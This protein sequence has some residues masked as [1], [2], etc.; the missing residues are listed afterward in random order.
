MA[1][2]FSASPPGARIGLPANWVPSPLFSQ[3]PTALPCP[4]EER[5]RRVVWSYNGTVPF[6]MSCQLSGG[7]RDMVVVVAWW[8]W[9]GGG[10]GGAVGMVWRW[11]WQGGRSKGARHCARLFAS[12]SCGSV[13]VLSG[14]IWLCATRPLSSGV[15]LSLSWVSIER[16]EQC[17]GWSMEG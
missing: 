3:S 13:I 7:A 5:A 1:A 15:F 9:C 10:D 11:R 16:Q 6:A 4:G 17:V 2:A 12:H 8:G 14:A